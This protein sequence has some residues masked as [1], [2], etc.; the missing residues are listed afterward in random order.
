MSADCGSSEAPIKPTFA[1]A[2]TYWLRLGAISFGGPAGQIAIMQHDLVDRLKWIRQNDFLHALNFCMLLPGPE[3][4]QL[5]TYIGWR[6]HGLRGG[7]VA[8]ILFVVP[9][10]ALLLALSWIAAAHGDV[11]WVAKIFS[12]LKPIVVTIIV[13]ALWRTARRG[14]ASRA[15]GAMALAAFA[16]VALI[17]IPFPIVVLAAALVGWIAGRSGHSAWFTA[18]THGDPPAGPGDGESG[19]GL[20]RV[21]RIAAAY[22]VLI[23]VPTAVLMAVSDSMFFPSLAWLFTKA[24]FVTFGGAYAVLPYVADAAVN[25]LMWL[26]AED[27]MNGLA[28]AETTPGPLILVL[29]YVGYFAGWNALSAQA[30]AGW[31][32]PDLALVAAAFTTYATFLPSMCLILA[33]APFIGRLSVM[34]AVSAALGAI[35]AAV[36]G[37]IG[38]LALFFA[39]SALVPGGHFD[40]VAATLSAVAL[41]VHLRWKVAIHWLILAGAAAGLLGG[42]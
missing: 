1:E 17:E 27:M 31:S 23:A 3:A 4:Q 40:A 7:L 30:A 25:D 20:S 6:L 24:A 15:A 8:G 35:T 2:L 36:V 42:V 33:G 10:A 9:G 32:A 34:P 21:I 14:L 18:P 16:A 39:E 13:G 37:V 19:P 11:G 5:A 38:T 28:L 29:Q 22:V 41:L 26:S 12:G